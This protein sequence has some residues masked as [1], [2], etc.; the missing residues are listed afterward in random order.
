MRKP[1]RPFVVTGLQ[2]RIQEEFPMVQGGGCLLFFFCF[3][4]SFFFF[5]FFVFSLQSM[6]FIIVA[7]DYFAYSHKLD[8]NT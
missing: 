1:V 2:I 6:K 5:V 8:S 4:S 3:F 7:S